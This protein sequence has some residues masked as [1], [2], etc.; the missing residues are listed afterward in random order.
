MRDKGGD[1]DGGAVVVR[2]GGGVPMG[3]AVFGAPD[4]PDGTVEA[5]V[6]AGGFVV[7]DVEGGAPMGGAVFA[8][9]DGAGGAEATGGSA[10]VPDVSGGTVGDVSSGGG[11]RVPAATLG[12]VGEPA[13]TL[14]SD[15]A[16]VLGPVSAA[17]LGSAPAAVVGSVPAAVLGVFALDSALGSVAVGVSGA[18]PS[19][20]ALASVAS[21][22]GS[23]APTRRVRPVPMQAVARARV[24][25]R[26]R[27]QLD[28]WASL[29]GGSRGASG[30]ATPRSVRLGGGTRGGV[31]RALL[32]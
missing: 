6:D 23:T 4:V 8:A 14:G 29:A 3:G 18:A 12:P 13:P 30:K 9:P 21:W 25:T 17:V 5:V 20:A 11:A 2:A 19:V 16:A 22:L 26:P 7:A 24:Q 32:E 27:R 31:C 10:D 1:V 15:P 28:I